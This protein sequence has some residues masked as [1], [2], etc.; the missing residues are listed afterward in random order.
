MKKILSIMLAIM[1]VLGLAA[2]GSSQAN[3]NETTQEQ[4]E[5]SGTEKSA[6]EESTTRYAADDALSQA[7]FDEAERCLCA[8]YQPIFPAN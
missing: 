1:L 3:S 2:C 7:D 6:P 4:S 8:K 5:S